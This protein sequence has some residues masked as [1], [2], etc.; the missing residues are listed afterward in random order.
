MTEAHPDADMVK[1]TRTTTTYEPV[2][3]KAQPAVVRRRNRTM[4]WIVG[5]CV[6]AVLAIAGLYYATTLNNTPAATQQD[7]AAAS[8]QNAQT[9]SQ[10]ATAAQQ[11]ADT[12]AA[13][14]RT[15]SAAATKDREDARRAAVGAA[16]SRDAAATAK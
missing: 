10:Q 16:D 9:L 7:A 15:L 12:S 4:L 14:T 6:V 8:Q 2:E 11:A 5:A 3:A 13:Q 1:V